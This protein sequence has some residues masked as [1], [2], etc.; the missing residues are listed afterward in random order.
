[1]AM[2]ASSYSKT[3]PSFRLAT[4]HVIRDRA[5]S[6]CRLSA[7][8]KTI[9]HSLIHKHTISQWQRCIPYSLALR[10]ILISEKQP[11]ALP[12]YIAYTWPMIYAVHT[13][14]QTDRKTEAC[15]EQE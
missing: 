4:S 10:V 14:A 3:K 5:V 2:A 6:S 9:T 1:M 12:S 13:V 8:T 7:T 15:I 11:N